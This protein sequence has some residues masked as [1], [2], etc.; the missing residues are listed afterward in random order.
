FPDLLQKDETDQKGIHMMMRDHDLFRQ[1]AASIKETLDQDN[2]VTQ[3]MIYEFTSL[4]IINGLHHNGEEKYMFNH[5]ASKDLN[6]L[7]S[8]RF[9]FWK[10]EEGFEPPRALTPLSVFKTDPFNQTWV[11]LQKINNF[12]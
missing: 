6:D 1:I 7:I 5:E 10:E 8:L 11:F 12:I 3:E 2:K 9:S 4:I